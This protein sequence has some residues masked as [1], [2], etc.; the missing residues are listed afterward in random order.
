MPNA[1]YEEGTEL[2][3]DTQVLAPAAGWA[4]QA[5]GGSDVFRIGS[6][7]TLTIRAKN[8]AKAA[9]LI[10]TLPPP[11]RPPV[12][13]IDSA[14]KIEVKANG[15]VVS[16]DGVVALEASVARVYSISYRAAGVSP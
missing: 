15:E 16:L 10:T 7:V 14:G 9:A 2:S 11:Y 8:A 12:A 3:L 5:G 6:L 4:D 1:T 13:V